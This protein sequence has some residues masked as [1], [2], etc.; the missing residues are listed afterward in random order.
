MNGLN[1]NQKRHLLSTVKHV[2]S[3][4]GDAFQVLSSAEA[5]S[6]FQSYIPDALPVQRK[7]IGDYLIRLRDLMVRILE[8]QGIA[9]PKPDISSVASFRNALLF[10]QIAVEELGP[11]YMRGYGEVSDEVAHELNVLTAQIKDVLDGMNDYLVR[12]S[13]EKNGTDD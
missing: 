4:L 13:A 10:A 1:D 12:G 8:E 5:S 6:P 11:R 9:I 3:L 2:D 7:V